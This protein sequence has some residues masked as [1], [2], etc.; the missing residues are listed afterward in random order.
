MAVEQAVYQGMAL[1]PEQRPQSVTEWLALLSAASGTQTRSLTEIRT[2]ATVQ[3]YAPIKPNLKP[4][5]AKQ[6]LT[7]SSTTVVASPK[8]R[9]P[10]TG[11]A[12]TTP[13]HRSLT[14]ALLTTG[15][16]A[17]LIGAGFGLVLRQDRLSSPN[18]S[19]S[20]TPS[21]S[22]S[23]VLPAPPAELSD[24]EM[25]E[26]EP[27]PD[28]FTDQNSSDPEP[29]PDSEATSDPNPLQA[30][31]LGEPAAPEP[32][33]APAPPAPDPSPQPSTS[34]APLPSFKLPATPESAP[35]PGPVVP[36][37]LSSP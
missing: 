19:L 24:P 5:T 3:V 34:L 18:P 11:P 1:E 22:A 28:P 33:A 32:S 16:V 36:N 27:P 17:A 6:P 31:D 12:K 9:Y 37:P 8:P 26:A 2:A 14:R 4:S 29:Y 15:I 25:P 30:P 13:W 35:Q 7:S 21:P 23:M 20:P 10:V